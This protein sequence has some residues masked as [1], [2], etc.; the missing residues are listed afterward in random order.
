[1]IATHVTPNERAGVVGRYR[2]GARIARGGMGEV[3]KGRDLD[4]GREFAVKVLLEE[5]IDSLDLARRFVEEAQIAGQLAHPGIAPGVRAR[6][7]RRRT[8]PTSP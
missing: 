7:L 8:A 1:M 6:R 5:H 4:L 2:F 3:F